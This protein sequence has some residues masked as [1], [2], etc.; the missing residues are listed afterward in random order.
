MINI[1]YTI[2]K[3]IVYHSQSEYETN[4]SIQQQ[5]CSKTPFNIKSVSHLFPTIEANHQGSVMPNNTCYVIQ[6]DEKLLIQILF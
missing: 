2:K 4:I 6:L 3:S 1:L 5:F